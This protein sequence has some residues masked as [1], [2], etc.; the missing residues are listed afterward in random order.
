MAKPLF[1]KPLHSTNEIL[2]NMGGGDCGY[3]FLKKSQ[4]TFPLNRAYVNSLLH[5]SNFICQ[6]CIFANLLGSPT[7]N[8]LWGLVVI[9]NCEIHA[10]L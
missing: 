2:L 6:C 9:A 4:V 10:V 3:Q 5:L 7:V 8:R 1:H